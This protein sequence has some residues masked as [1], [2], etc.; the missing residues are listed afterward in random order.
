MSETR[1]SGGNLLQQD[2]ADGAGEN[3]L[4]GAINRKTNYTGERGYKDEM[5]EMIIERLQMQ[6]KPGQFAQ[7]CAW[8]AKDASLEPLPYEVL[9]LSA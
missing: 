5:A 4:P 7:R 1:G 9:R 3:A 2:G 8:R 6:L